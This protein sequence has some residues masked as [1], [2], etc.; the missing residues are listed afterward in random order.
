MRSDNAQLRWAEPASRSLAGCRGLVVG[1]HVLRFVLGPCDGLQIVP[2]GLSHFGRLV[3][4]AAFDCLD[5]VEQV[6]CAGVV[7]ERVLDVVLGT[8]ASRRSFASERR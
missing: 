2:G 3:E 5:A 4:V 8:A 6:P 1:E 7:D